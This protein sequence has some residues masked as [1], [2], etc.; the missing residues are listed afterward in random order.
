MCSFV[1][2]VVLAPNVSV[3]ALDANPAV[4]K[5]FPMMCTVT[6]AKGIIIGSVN[7]T[8]IFNGTEFGGNK[9]NLT[10]SAEYVSWYN[11]TKLQPRDN[12]TVY[13]CKATINTALMEVD[14]NDSIKIDSI[15]LGTCFIKM[16]VATY[17]QSDLPQS[18]L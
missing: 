13:Y 5:S 10:N 1:N 9:Y 18:S 11:I 2:S 8:W 7:I 6:V 4:G 3:T 15:S 17:V 12:N 16:H 14:G